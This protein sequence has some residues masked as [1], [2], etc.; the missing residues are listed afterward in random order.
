MEGLM[1]VTALFKR[2]GNITSSKLLRKGLSESG[3]ISG[4]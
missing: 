1:R 2:L 4:A 3:A